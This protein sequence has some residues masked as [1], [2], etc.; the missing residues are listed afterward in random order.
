MDFFVKEHIALV[1][2]K[3]VWAKSQ[4][5]L[6]RRQLAEA[7]VVR[8]F[9]EELSSNLSAQHPASVLLIFRQNSNYVQ[10]LC[11]T[12][13]PMGAVL[14]QI[15]QDSEARASEGAKIFSRTFPTA[16]R[17]AGIEPDKT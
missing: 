11:A 2:E 6:A 3:V 10:R 5:D 12:D 8:R 15:R 13:D 17:E 7:E 14:Q 16:I 4:E 9:W 1:A